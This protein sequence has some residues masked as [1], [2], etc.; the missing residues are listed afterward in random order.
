MRMPS[1]PTAVSTWA[2]WPVSIG[3]EGEYVFLW[4]I[5][6]GDAEHGSNFDLVCALVVDDNVD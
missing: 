1:D 3:R 4:G 2:V 6:A 5:A